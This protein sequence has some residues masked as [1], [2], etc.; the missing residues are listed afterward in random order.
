L[1]VLW[2]I[3]HASLGLSILGGGA[4][5]AVAIVASGGP[6]LLAI[7]IGAL[8][9][10]IFAVGALVGFVTIQIEWELRYYVLTD[11]SLRI[12]E[13]VMLLSEVTLTLANVQEINVEQGPIQRW[14]GISDIVVDTAGGGASG[15]GA[16][17]SHRGILRGIDRGSVIRQRLEQRVKERRGAGLG[18]PDDHHDH[19]PALP[20]PDPFLAAL[21]AV[22]DEARA[23]HQAL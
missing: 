15:Q 16:G 20:G 13:G 12:R 21:T 5:A 17:N 1:L 6:V 23:L 22:R 7:A 11:R 9:L 4:A 10:V 2:A 8:A 19:A 18:D 14:L 3:R